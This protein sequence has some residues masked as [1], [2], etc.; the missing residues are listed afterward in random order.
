MKNIETWK[1]KNS[2]GSLNKNR[3]KRT[4]SIFL[5]SESSS[6]IFD[7]ISMHVYL[8]WH[9]PRPFRDRIKTF[10][11]NKQR[12]GNKI[13]THFWRK[14]KHPNSCFE[15]LTKTWARRAK[16]GHEVYWNQIEMLVFSRKYCVDA[17][18]KIENRP[19]TLHLPP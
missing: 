6:I 13:L 19:P 9:W 3:I 8:I 11:R 17:V 10:D 4:F 7:M 5:W 18:Y 14:R 12:R 16:Q 2:K 1:K 15:A